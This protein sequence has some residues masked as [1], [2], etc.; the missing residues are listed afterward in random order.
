MPRMA[1]ALE[2]GEIEEYRRLMRASGD[3]SRRQLQNI[4][5]DSH[6]EETRLAQ[7]LDRSAE[8][9]GEKGAWRV[10]GGGF[11]GS[12]QA[13]VP[14]EDWERYRAAMDELFGEN[15]CRELSVRPMGAARLLCRIS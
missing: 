1:A 12:I 15:A 11:G 5:P 10:H 13:L 7:A 9:L 3:S 6:P 4:I 14:A 2:R 8:L